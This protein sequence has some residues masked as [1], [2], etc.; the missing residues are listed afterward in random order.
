MAC[1]RLWDFLF[2]FGDPVSHFNSSGCLYSLMR[3]FRTAAWV[4]N[5]KLLPYPA[6][7]GTFSHRLTEKT[8]PEEITAV[9]G[10][11]NFGI[12]VIKPMK[13]ARKSCKKL[14]TFYLTNAKIIGPH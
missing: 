3:A 9:G 10:L 14:L 6:K 12:S 4:I 13:I 8:G 2:P 1:R 11:V 7:H 5:V